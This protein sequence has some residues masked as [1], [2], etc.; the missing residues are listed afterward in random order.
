M[1]DAKS[2]LT[3]TDGA[4]FPDTLT[5][6]ATGAGTGDG[7]ELVKA[8]MDQFLGGFY[9]LMDAAGL[10]PDSLTEAPGTSQIVESVQRLSKPRRF[11]ASSDESQTASTLPA[12]MVYAGKEG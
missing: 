3:Y 5:V 2:T 1:I 8:L 7:T 11:Q 6:N 9:S 12:W 4:N 10:T